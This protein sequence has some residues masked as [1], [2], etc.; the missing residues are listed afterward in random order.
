MMMGGCSMQ[1]G[2]LLIA[3][4]FGYIVWYL[5]NREEKDLRVVG[6]VIGTIIMA[7][8]LFFI[9]QVLAFSANFFSKFGCS[10]IK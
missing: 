9:I 4:G 3:L 5:S 2:V 6:K 1:I 8:S 7:L 10:M